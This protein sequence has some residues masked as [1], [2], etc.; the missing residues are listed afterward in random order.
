[1]IHTLL[2]EVTSE[3]RALPLLRTGG[4]CLAHTSAH[5]LAAISMAAVYT[6][7]VHIADKPTARLGYSPAV[8]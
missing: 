4:V 1:M 8:A 5:H 2:E 7:A 6:D 3:H